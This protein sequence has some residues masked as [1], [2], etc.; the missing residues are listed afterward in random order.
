MKA[1][2]PVPEATGATALA[3]KPRTQ[4][5]GG[6]SGVNDSEPHATCIKSRRFTGFAKATAAGLCR[7]QCWDKNAL[8]SRRNGLTNVRRDP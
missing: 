3:T 1:V 2:V 5:G 7:Q 6:D 8:T 4:P